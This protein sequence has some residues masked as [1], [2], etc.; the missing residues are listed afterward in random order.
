M[1]INVFFELIPCNTT[2][3]IYNTVHAQEKIFSFDCL[4]INSQY[5]NNENN[6][7]LSHQL[8]PKRVRRIRQEYFAVYREYAD[9]HEFSIKPKKILDPT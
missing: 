5:I 7:K 2:S 3:T 6:Q 1:K 9:R 8:T 4:Y